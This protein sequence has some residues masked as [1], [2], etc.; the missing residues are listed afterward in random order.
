MGAP[1]FHVDAFTD[2]PF[3]GNP[4]AVCVLSE[5]RDDGWL[6]SV[7]GEMN[8]AETAYL[9]RKEPGWQLRWFTPAVEVDLCGHATLASAH[10]LW[11]AGYARRGTTLLFETRSGRLSAS[12]RNNGGAIELDFPAEPASASAPPPDLLAS[13]G[14]EAAGFTGRNRLDYLVQIEGERVLRRLAPD[15]KR[16]AAACGRARG[17]IVTAASDRPE[18]DFVSRYFAPGAGIDEDPVTG[19]AHCCL[20]PFWAERLGKKELSGYQA[21]ARGGTVAVRVEETRVS[22]AGRAVIIARGE[23]V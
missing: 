23:L 21:S 20:G 3:A 19:S 16:L 4:A 10:V 13:L 15:F 12:H 22:L 18:H 6:Q 14:I 11:E 17:V 9:W 7:A 2:R 1:I 8:L 5:Q